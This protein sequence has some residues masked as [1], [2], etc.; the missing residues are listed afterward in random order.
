MTKENEWDCQICAYCPHI[1]MI[2]PMKVPTGPI[3]EGEC[4]GCVVEGVV[5]NGVIA[6]LKPRTATYKGPTASS[7]GYV[8][9]D[10]DR[11]EGAALARTDLTAY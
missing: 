8:A 10:V 4:G 7:P 9:A 3:V 2:V 6:Q 1:G 11:C 5:F